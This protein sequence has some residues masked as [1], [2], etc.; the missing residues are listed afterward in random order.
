MIYDIIVALD[1]IRDDL[2]L[3][4]VELPIRDSRAED[5]IRSMEQTNKVVDELVDALKEKRESCWNEKHT[6]PE[7]FY[8]MRC[9]ELAAELLKVAQEIPMMASHAYA[10][11]CFGS[12]DKLKDAV[13]KK[14]ANLLAIPEV[15]AIMEKKP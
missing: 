1:L 14:V 6:N 2:N 8:K 11:L 12:S 9:M 7:G 15:A 10:E 3:I 5:R 13:N 4:C